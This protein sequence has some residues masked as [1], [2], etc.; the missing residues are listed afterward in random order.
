MFSSPRDRHVDP[1]LESRLAKSSKLKAAVSANLKS[2]KF[3]L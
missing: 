1:E 3:T 2:L